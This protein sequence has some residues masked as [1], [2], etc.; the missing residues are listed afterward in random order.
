[1][2][3]TQIATQDTGQSQQLIV[4]LPPGALNGEPILPAPTGQEDNVL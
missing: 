1:M 2:R 4:E 3:P